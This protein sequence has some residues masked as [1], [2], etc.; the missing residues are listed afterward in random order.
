MVLRQHGEGW[1]RWGR[2]VRSDGS[3]RG[4]R[5][6]SSSRGG[7]GAERGGRGPH[8]GLQAAERL[9]KAGPGAGGAA[10]LQPALGPLCGPGRAGGSSGGGPAPP[11]RRAGQARSVGRGAAA[12]SG[13]GLASL[14]HLSARTKGAGPEAPRAPLSRRQLAECSSRTPPKLSAFPLVPPHQ[15]QVGK[16]GLGLFFFFFLTVPTFTLSRWLFRLIIFLNE[17]CVYSR[18]QIFKFL[19]CNIT[20][21]RDF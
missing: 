16:A 11:W 5:S 15:W 21:N 9:G 13:T 6:N 4:R 20:K 10:P 7:H 12:G 17:T 14:R 19:I 18:R 3:G 2:R 1:G 8:P